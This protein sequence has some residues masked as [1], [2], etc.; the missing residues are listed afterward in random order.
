MSFLEK[1]LNFMETKTYLYFMK[2]TK[3]YFYKTNESKNG[4]QDYR[5]KFN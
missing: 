3:Y 1:L 2:I 5:E 4:N